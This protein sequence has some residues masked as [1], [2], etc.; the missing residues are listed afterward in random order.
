MVL[1]PS[2][3]IFALLYIVDRKPQPPD[4]AARYPRRVRLVIKLSTDGVVKSAHAI[5]EP[6][7]KAS[8]CPAK[9]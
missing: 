6:T 4:Y 9:R 3:R 7:D 1:S 5:I 8:I 2:V